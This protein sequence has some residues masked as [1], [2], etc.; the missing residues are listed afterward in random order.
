MTRGQ[1]VRTVK[2]VRYIKKELH[3]Q[4]WDFTEI[5]TVKYTNQRGGLHFYVLPESVSNAQ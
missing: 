2:S 5:N 4:Y 1:T 3:L